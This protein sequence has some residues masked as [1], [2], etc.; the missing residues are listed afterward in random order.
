MD[1]KEGGTKNSRILIKEKGFLCYTFF[2]KKCGI[3]I[4]LTFLFIFIKNE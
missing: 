2:V 3:S 1:V 4:T